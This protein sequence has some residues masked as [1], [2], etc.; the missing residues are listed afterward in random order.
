MIHYE[1]LIDPTTIDTVRRHINCQTS[2]IRE[3]LFVS[4]L[5]LLPTVALALDQAS[6][7]SSHRRLK[8]WRT[9]LETGAVVPGHAGTYGVDL[10]TLPGESFCR[11]IFFPPV[12]LVHVPG[13]DIEHHARSGARYQP[14][15]G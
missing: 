13:L 12:Y 1:Q 9:W 6:P 14:L 3:V 4:D 5:R 15:H 11:V 2:S 8:Q 7:Q 10:E